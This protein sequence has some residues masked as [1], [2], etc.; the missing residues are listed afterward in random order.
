MYNTP[1][2]NCAD[3]YFLYATMTWLHLMLSEFVREVSERNSPEVRM[4][5]CSLL[6]T[7]QQYAADLSAACILVAGSLPRW[8][9][10]GIRHAVRL[11][12]ALRAKV[13][14]NKSWRGKFSNIVQRCAPCVWNSVLICHLRRKVYCWVRWLTV[15]WHIPQSWA[16]VTDL[17]VGKIQVKTYISIIQWAVKAMRQCAEPSRVV[18]LMRP[19]RNF[20]VK[21]QWDSKSRFKSSF[22]K[23]V[24]HN[25]TQSER[26]F[27]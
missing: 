21:L 10:T 2:L 1:P 4:Q 5:D 23:T 18:H 9:T 27:L 12:I 7:I 11:V 24:L 22:F 26:N 13:K 6:N 14:Q 17:M 3:D 16:A 25:T 19:S 8:V 15:I 20:S